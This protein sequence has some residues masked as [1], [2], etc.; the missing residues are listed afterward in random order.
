MA[1]RYGIYGQKPPLAMS[2][3]VQ[4]DSLD[5]RREDHREIGLFSNFGYRDNRSAQNT[6]KRGHEA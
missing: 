3:A 2:V 6:E 1:V 4:I 5:A